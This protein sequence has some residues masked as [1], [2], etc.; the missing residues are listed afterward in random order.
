MWDPGSTLWELLKSELTHLLTYLFKSDCSLDG[1]LVQ[2]CS[3]NWADML[4]VVP[5]M[6]RLTTSRRHY[7]QMSHG[8]TVSCQVSRP[9]FT[10]VLTPLAIL[11]F[12]HAILSSSFQK[13]AS[14]PKYISRRNNM[15]N[16]QGHDWPVLDLWENQ[17]GVSDV[18]LT[19][20]DYFSGS[21]YNLGGCWEAPEGGLNPPTPN[22]SSTVIDIQVGVDWK[23][24]KPIQQCY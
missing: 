19:Y 22:K 3:L 9:W 23:M 17:R 8:V 6:S 14:T 10:S 7:K 12:C 4:D 16:Y 15:I 13:L 24:S 11:T 21:Q 1:S 5:D 18:F 20:F 2:F